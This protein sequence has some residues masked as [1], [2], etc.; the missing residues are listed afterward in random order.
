MT[1]TITQAHN[2]ARLAGTL[3]FLDTGA[4]NARCRI[5]TGTRPSTASDT[6]TSAMLVEI[7]LTKPAGT[8]ADGQLALTQV[9][10]G[11]ITNSGT[12]TWARFVNGNGDTAFDAD[13][14]NGSNQGEVVMATTQLFAG[15]DAKLVSCLLG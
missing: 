6:P 4:G 9:E 5:Y 3:G 11:L 1:I 10:D 2:E 8:V 7:T 12:A 14:D 13:V 15:G